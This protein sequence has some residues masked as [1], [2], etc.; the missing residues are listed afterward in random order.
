MPR[1]SG[2][3]LRGLVELRRSDR[4]GRHWRSRRRR[5]RLECRRRSARGL[6]WAE[7]TDALA[8]GLHVI[9][10]GGRRD[11]T[12]ARRDLANREPRIGLERSERGL[13]DLEEPRRETRPDLLQRVDLAVADREQD[14]E[15]SST[16]EERAIQEHLREHGREAEEIG[17]MIAPLPGHLLGREIRKLPFENVT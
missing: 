5:L 2:S 10:R 13:H 9:R 8:N 3:L 11:P 4:R 1:R 6:R 12:N 7:G 16:G 17:A 15:L 14:G